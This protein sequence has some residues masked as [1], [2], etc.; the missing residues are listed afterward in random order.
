MLGYENI[1]NNKE[2][3]AFLDKSTNILNVPYDSN[4]SQKTQ[5]GIGLCIKIQIAKRNPSR[6]CDGGCTECIGFR[7]DFV[8]F[9]CIVSHRQSREQTANVIVNE[10]TKTIEYH[11]QDDI[12]WDFME[13]NKKI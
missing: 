4:L 10:S 7:C 6:N 3:Q 9:P 2:S 5:P 8:T 13:N 1:V 11:F 12:D